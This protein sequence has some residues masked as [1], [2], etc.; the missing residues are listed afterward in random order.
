[1]CCR[2]RHVLFRYRMSSQRHSQLLQ[3]A[4]N[5][6]LAPGVADTPECTSLKCPFCLSSQAAKVV[7]TR[8]GQNW[9]P[10]F[11]SAGRPFHPL[12]IAEADMARDRAAVERSWPKEGVRPEPVHQQRPEEGVP[13]P[14]GI[15]ATA[16]T[17]K[18]DRREPSRPEGSRPTC[19]PV[20]FGPHGPSWQID[21]RCVGRSTSFGG[22]RRVH[23]SLRDELGRL[24]KGDD[25]LKGHAR[26]MGAE[27]G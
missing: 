17:L 23:G 27:P 2:A 14:R 8:L 6:V 3:T 10:R 22:S 9:T 1:M 13:A 18:W 15:E 26:L 12:R 20:Q 16:P 25:V 21:R 19:W 5:G 4:S 7:C 24:I 11:R